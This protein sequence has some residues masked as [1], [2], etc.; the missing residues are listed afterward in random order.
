MNKSTKIKI[1]LFFVTLISIKGFT[2]NVTGTVIDQEKNPLEFVAVAL[3]NPLDSILISYANTDKFGKFKLE[4]VPVGKSIFQVHLLGYKTQQKIIDFKKGS[5]NLGTFTLE[6][7]NL[8]DEVLVNAIIPI[9]IKKDTV[10]YNTKA[11]KI[12]VD[13]SV[14]DLLKKLPGVEVDAAGKVTAQGEEVAKVYVDGKEF[15]SG[16]PTIATKNLSADA[17]KSVEIIDEKSEKSRV[18][19]VNDSERS[20]VINLILKDD[21]KVND[22]GKLQAGYGT[23]DRY[24]TSLN[25]N[26]F[27]S[28]LQTSI[29]GKYNNVNTS[30]SDISEIISF[31]T[32]GGRRG[33]STNTG[34]GFLTTGVG[35]FNLGYELK[36]DQN[37]NADYF[38]NYTSF[39]SGDVSTNR[40][41][42]IGNTE[43]R[44]ESKSESEN[45]SNRNNA[46]F[47]YRDRSNKLS[48]LTIRGNGNISRNKG[49]SLNTLDKYNGQNELDLQSVGSSNSDTDNSSGN[50]SFNYTK[51]FKESSKR[52]MTVIGGV[53]S[54]KT[55]SDSHNNQTNIFN[56][57]DPSN[58]F[59]LNQKI[60]KEQSKTANSVN[61]KLEY[62]EPLSEKHL[63]EIGGGVNYNSND[64]DVNQTKF[65]DGIAQNPLVYSEFYKK[66]D[67]SGNI[68]YKYDNDKFTLSAGV[69][70]IEQTQDFGLENESEFKNSYT[71]INPE[72]SIRYNPERGEFLRFRMNKSVNLPSLSEVS[73]A[74]NDFNPLYISQGN[75]NLT[76]E[77]NY[78]VSGFYG[79]HNFATGLSLFFRLSYNYTKNSIGNTEFTDPLGIRF[80]SYE[81]LGDKNNFSTFFHFGN[82]INSLGIR[83]SFRINGSYSEYFSEINSAINETQTKSGTLALSLENNKK[84]KVD[85]SIGASWNKNY[86]TFTS[87]NNADRDYLKQSYYTKLDWNVTNRFNIVS[88]FKYDIYTDSNFGTDEGVPIW[89]AT[90]SYGLNESKSL[91]IMISALDILNKNIGIERNSSDNYFEEVNKEVLG[92]YYML[93]LTYNLNG[94]KGPKGSSR[95]GRRSRR[96]FH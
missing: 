70:I 81:N 28:K 25:Y 47:S 8:L 44:S 53:N 71:D 20:K 83:Y 69:K 62:V 75:P 43:I 23:D 89:N 30:G 12:R 56:F 31:N 50:I 6:N 16:D 33:R 14:E 19:G 94:N 86:T 52:N 45:I 4:N 90:V 24:L 41:E 26:R 72:L 2:Q 38:Y 95:G 84:E 27:S 61:F 64:N 22:F 66:S 91:T 82:R 15:F 42:F 65:L 13:D 51:R 80:S 74:I 17:I 5:T 3:I 93:S 1:L 7:D 63:I 35:G 21:K 60:D 55:N 79:K 18:S 36:K 77:D 32:G 46:N 40:T 37:L 68:G 92:N 39:N 29:I 49:T 57:S 54:S 9:S 10:A 78:S 67:L 96:S 85:A 76:P 88:Q 59:E 58:K 11:F 34:A 87:G 48:S 73:P